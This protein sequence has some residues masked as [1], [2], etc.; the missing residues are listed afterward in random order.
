VDGLRKRPLAAG[1]D[2]DRLCAKHIGVAGAVFDVAADGWPVNSKIAL[3]EGPL[4][5]APAS[6][7]P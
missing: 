2:T 5:P 1:P 3:R 7:A 4:T 6:R